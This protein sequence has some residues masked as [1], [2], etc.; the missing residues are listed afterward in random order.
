MLKLI[1]SA[2]KIGFSGISTIRVPTPKILQHSLSSKYWFMKGTQLE[3][4]VYGEDSPS[5]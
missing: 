4:L 5:N 2:S 1:A 3:Q